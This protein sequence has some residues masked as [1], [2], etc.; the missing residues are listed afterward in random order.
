MKRLIDHQSKF[1]SSAMG[2]PGSYTDDHL[3]RVHARL[4]ITREAFDVVGGLLKE[5]MEEHGVEDPD[6]KACSTRSSSASR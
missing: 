4:G 3:E 2:G 6:V 5:A 1:I